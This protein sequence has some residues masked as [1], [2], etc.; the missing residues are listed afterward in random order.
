MASVDLKSLVARLNDTCRRALEAAAGVTLSRSHYNVEIEHYLLSLADRTDTDCAAI[1]KHYGVDMARFA[2]DLGKALDRMKTGNAR[3][4][5]LSPEIVELAKQAWLLGSIEL[6][7]SRVRSGHI[8]LAL[9]S[10]ETLARR[11]REASGQ[12]ARIPAD[13]LKRDYN[14][15]CGSTPESQRR[16]GARR[17]RHPAVRLRAWRPRAARHRRGA[18]RPPPPPPR[19]RSAPARNP[20]AARRAARPPHPGSARASSRSS[21]PAAP[22]GRR[23]GTARPCRSVPRSSPAGPACGSAARR[24]PRCG[25]ER[26]S[27]RRGASHPPPR[28]PAAR[29]ARCFPR[30]APGRGPGSAGR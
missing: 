22:A 5:S 7:A 26:R 11:A 25:H 1:L 12:F 10:D 15:I 17:H 23:P 16:R 19:P 8:I 21:P 2:A 28:S 29:T 6:G 24:R 9:V 20:F 14:A 27:R 30:C 3:A 18:P 13:Q 4:P